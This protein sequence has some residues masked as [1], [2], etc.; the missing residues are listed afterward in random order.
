ML[1]E[2]FEKRD[3]LEKIQLEISENLESERLK[4]HGK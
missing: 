3:E 4:R 1:K 2:E